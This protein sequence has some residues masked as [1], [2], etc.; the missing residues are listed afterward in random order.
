MEFARQSLGLLDVLVEANP[1]DRHAR[2]L[3]GEGADL[4]GVTLAR[5]GRER[6][7]RASWQRAVRILQPIAAGTQDPLF[8]DP[9]ARV[10]IRLGRLEEALPIVRQLGERGYRHFELRRLCQQ[11]GMIVLG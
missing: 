5:S 7:A 2:R 9:L 11:E 3:V 1:D 6:E 4:L 10:L 8:L